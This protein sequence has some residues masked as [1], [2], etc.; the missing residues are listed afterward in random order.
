MNFGQRF[1][2]LRL[3]KGLTQQGLAED[4]NKI[5]G[6]T[7]S[8]SS[9]SQYENGKRTPENEALKNFALYF[10]VSIDYLLCIDDI[11]YNNI[12][13]Q[14][15]DLQNEILTEASIFSVM[16]ILIE[17]K[18]INFLKNYLKCILILYKLI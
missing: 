16:R 9:I 15:Q 11:R 17:M 1:K 4:F 8:K 12:D 5:Y 13:I 2:K 14:K 18:K 6:H 10:N 7:F 3:E